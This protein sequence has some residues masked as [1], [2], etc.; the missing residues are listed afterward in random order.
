[1]RFAISKTGKTSLRQG[2]KRTDLRAKE[3]ALNTPKQG[4]VCSESD[5]AYCSPLLV[6]SCGIVAT[7]LLSLAHINWTPLRRFLHSENV[8]HSRNRRHTSKEGRNQLILHRKGARREICQTYQGRAHE[9]P[10]VVDRAYGSSGIPR[11]LHDTK[12]TRIQGSRQKRS[13]SFWLLPLSRRPVSKREGPRTFLCKSRPCIG[14][15]SHS[16]FLGEILW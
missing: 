15:F 16:S 13:K 9:R 6:L 2:N 10:H 1:M 5:V 12:P 14:F 7:N 8:S 4:L 11:H 3:P